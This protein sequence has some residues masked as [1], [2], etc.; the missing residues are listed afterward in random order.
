MTYPGRRRRRCPAGYRRVVADAPDLRP[1][2]T[3]R[4]TGWH[5][6]AL[7]ALAALAAIAFCVAAALEP[8]VPGG[9]QEPTWV[10]VTLAVLIG[11]PIA[12]RRRWPLAVL[13]S[14]FGVSVGALVGG[15]IP[16]FAMAAPL[17]A[18]AVVVYA[19]GLLVPRRRSVPALVLCLILIAAAAAGAELMKP[20]GV[21]DA[22]SM[23]AGIVF[24]VVVLGGA[25]TVGRAARERRAYARRSAE[26]VAH[27][28][29]TDE[30]LRIARE[31]HD[32]VAHSMSLIA[33]KAAIANHVADARPEQARETLRVIETTSR[34]ALAEMRRTLGALRGDAGLP[35]ELAPAPGLADLPE[36][37]E[38][39]GAAGVRV[40]L[41][42]DA[43]LELPDG[44]GLS[45]YRI[46]QE[47]LTNVV[48]HAGRARCRVRVT[49]EDGAVRIRVLD[50]GPGGAEPA[51]RD[52]PGQGH[53]LV[54]MRER[55]ALY[56][57]TLTAASRPSGGFEVRA[58]LPYQS[59]G[60]LS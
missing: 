19:A 17:C 16:T 29:V 30:R 1:L 42:V 46:V 38:R 44:V 31:V 27:Q 49:A 39:A 48:R 22:P 55:V 11:A 35:A 33:V 2:L 57:G 26:Q 14:V 59:T 56:G 28:A 7:D 34:G 54:G 36:L 6:L 45:V 43:G 21:M 15:V 60:T 13:A 40:D 47:S 37:V 52:G 53:G 58:D 12:V 10:A 8:P 9:P 25:W 51:G 18:S 23:A 50:D 24:G 41:E 32:I 4:L 3:R 5:L 20:A